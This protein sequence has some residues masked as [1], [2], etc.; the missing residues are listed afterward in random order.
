[1]Q[2]TPHILLVDEDS[3]YATVFARGLDAV[4]F[5]TKQCLDARSA[6]TYLADSPEA[7]LVAAIVTE[8]L[9][10]GRNGLKL[11]QDIR[12]LKGHVNTPIIILTALTAAD[13]GLAASLQ[14]A[15]GIQAYFVKQQT[16]PED[17]ASAVRY[18]L[19]PA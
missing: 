4:G 15:L 1:M 7:T 8:V 17:V 18:A 3:S 6:L 9:L 16:R 2:E 19:E 10:P 11:I 14:E 12:L 5:T 13:V